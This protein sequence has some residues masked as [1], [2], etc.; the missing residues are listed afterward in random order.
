MSKKHSHRK[1]LRCEK[2]GNVLRPAL[3]VSQYD[4][5]PIRICP[6]CMV[7]EYNDKNKTIDDGQTSDEMS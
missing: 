5:K 1:K 7:S 6:V 4:E 2:C 3:R